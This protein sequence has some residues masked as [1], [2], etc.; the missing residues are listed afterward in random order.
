MDVAF[1]DEKKIVRRIVCDE[2]QLKRLQLD[3]KVMIYK[4]NAYALE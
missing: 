1:Y 3:S 2:K 4:S